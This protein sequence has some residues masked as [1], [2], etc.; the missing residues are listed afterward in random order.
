MTIR[1][2][3]PMSTLPGWMQPE[4]PKLRPLDHPSH[5][6]T[7]ANGVIAYY[8]PGYV[9]IHAGAHEPCVTIPRHQPAGIRAYAMA[10][11]LSS[12]EAGLLVEAVEAYAR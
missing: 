6:Y 5:S 7:Y 8:S 3:I 10:C 1:P 11:G 2:T 9:H 12:D 4:P